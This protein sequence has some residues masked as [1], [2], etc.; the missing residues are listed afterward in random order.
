V[1][2]L[3]WYQHS[4]YFSTE[5]GKLT[6]VPKPYS[7]WT[8]VAPAPHIGF[9]GHERFATFRGWIWSRTLPMLGNT[10]FVGYGPD[11][12]ATYF[13]QD[14]LAWKINLYGAPNIVVDKPHN[15]YLQTA[16]NTGVVSLLLL[17]WLLAA[18]VFDAL[19]VW[20]RKPVRGMAALFG[21]PV[22]G[23]P[24]ALLP[25]GAARDAIT[26]SDGPTAVFVA[27]PET[28]GRRI[29]LMGILCGVIG[30]AIAGM[31]N[32]SV[33][34]VAPLFWTVFGLGVGLLRFSPRAAVKAAAE[35]RPA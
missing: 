27:G 28:D 35:K 13:P 11:T 20:L 34:S 22:A 8:K 12:F 15:W 16:V 23:D 33:V 7:Y 17:V 3:S 6:Y 14:D 24:A 1:V 19:R 31:F 5:N 2:I 21:S 18:F 10:L 9:E 30:Y 25:E 29:L 4:F 26:A 32:D